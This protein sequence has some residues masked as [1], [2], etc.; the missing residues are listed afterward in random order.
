M[1]SKRYLKT[2]IKGIKR[3]NLEYL[4]NKNVI[5]KLRT[6]QKDTKSLKE[7]NEHLRNPVR[8]FVFDDYYFISYTLLV[9]IKKE[10]LDRYMLSCNRLLHENDLLKSAW[11]IILDQ[12]KST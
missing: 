9:K 6:W 5:G 11:L 10:G 12:M 1:R 4:F 3:R 7:P 8:E 2:K